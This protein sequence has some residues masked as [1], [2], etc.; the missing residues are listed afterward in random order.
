MVVEL[1]TPDQVK[2]E[3][4]KPGPMVLLYGAPWCP[5][6]QM[7]DPIYEKISENPRMKDVRF[8]HMNID[9]IALKGHEGKIPYI[10]T[11]FV[12]RSEDELRNRPCKILKGD[13]TEKRVI[14]EIQRCL[15]RK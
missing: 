2:V 11:A 8:Y 4:A 5:G 12:G 13:R 6:C 3:L 10:P 7:F 14:R 15:K 1:R 9:D